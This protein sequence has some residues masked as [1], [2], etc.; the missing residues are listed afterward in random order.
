M[1]ELPQL[2]VEMMSTYADQR[3]KIEGQ[4]KMFSDPTSEKLLPDQPPQYKSVPCPL[5]CTPPPPSI[6]HIT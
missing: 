3:S 6:A 1:S 2:W 4:V 5:S